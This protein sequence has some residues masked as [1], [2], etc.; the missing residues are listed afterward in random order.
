MKISEQVKIL[1]DELLDAR[2]RLVEAQRKIINYELNVE[3][4]KKEIRKKTA[5]AERFEAKNNQLM[6]DFAAVRVQKFTK[7]APIVNGVDDLPSY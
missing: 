5:R 6:E 4:W 1:E 2:E 7:Q 3:E